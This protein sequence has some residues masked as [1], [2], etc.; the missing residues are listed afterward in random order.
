MITA[1]ETP[2]RVKLKDGRELDAVVECERIKMGAGDA[3]HPQDPRHEPAE[4]LGD[5]EF[6]LDQNAEPEKDLD[7]G[8]LI[9]DVMITPETFREAEEKLIEN[10]PTESEVEED[11]KADEA[12]RRR[13]EGDE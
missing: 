8:E 7:P 2:I 12:D 5:L 9:P 1:I 11:A 4:I 10:T 3:H 13:D 6:F